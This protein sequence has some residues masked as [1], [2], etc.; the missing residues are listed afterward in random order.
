MALTYHH[1][2]IP[3]EYVDEALVLCKKLQERGVTFDT[4]FDSKGLHWELDWSIQGHMSA[5]DIL[6][7]LEDYQINYSVA[8]IR[9]RNL[10]D[11]E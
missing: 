4:G 9:D 8:L 1:V 6:L 2:T 3:F 5:Q 11:G 10:G 7:E